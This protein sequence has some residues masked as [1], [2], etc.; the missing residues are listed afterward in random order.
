MAI[1]E[2]VVEQ[3]KRKF[4]NIPAGRM[5][6]RDATEGLSWEEKMTLLSGVSISGVRTS[7]VIPTNPRHRS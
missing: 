6:T 5:D 7:P 1:R 2:N 3:A 4:N